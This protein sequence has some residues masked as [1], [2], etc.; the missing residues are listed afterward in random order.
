MSVFNI[1]R[2][3]EEP[4]EDTNNELELLKKLKQRI[5]PTPAPVPI[6]V[7]EDEVVKKIDEDDDVKAPKDEEQAVDEEA[8]SEKVGKKKK[9][10]R[11]LSVEDT[12]FTPLGDVASKE[13]AKVRRVLPKWLAQP[14]VVSVDLGDQQMA[15]DDMKELD[16]GL[17]ETLKSNGVKYFFPVQRQV[18]PQLLNAWKIKFFWPSD[19]CVSAPTGSGKTL[20]FVL[21]IIQTLKTRIVP[22]VRALVILPVQDLAVQVFKVFQ[23]Y[24]NK[25]N[26]RVKLISGQKSFSQEQTE[27]VVKGVDGQF[28]SLADIIIATPGRLVDHIQKT[29][30]FTLNHLRYLVIDEADRVMED[31]QNDWLSHVERSVYSGDRQKMT[32]INCANFMKYQTPLQKLLF[33]ATLS[34]NPEQLQQMSLYEPKLY[35][36]IVQPENIFASKTLESVKDNPDEDNFVGKYTTPSEL[37]E[38]ILEVQ[39]SMKKP[40]LLTNLIKDKEIKKTLVFTKSIDNC[41][42]LATLLKSSNMK[43]G[44]ISSKLKYQRSKTLKAFK[45]DK[46]DVLVSTDALA[47]GIDIG[48]IDLV[49]SYDVPK[50]VKTYIHRIGR[51]AR[52]GRAGKAVTMLETKKVKQFKS[53]LKEAGKST[54]LK[55]ESVEISEKDENVYE[56][57]LKKAKAVIDEE[58]KKSKPP[59]KK[60]ANKKKNKKKMKK[61]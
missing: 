28:F 12:G 54:D 24:A 46:L 52:A 55:E 37:T 43:V 44:E 53:L 14:D 58:N 16:E 57:S 6:K 41:H 42:Y 22:R 51:T 13:K 38:S 21:P 20:A 18:I 35:T 59:T 49:I 33:S 60:D 32:T 10:K 40:L 31:V 39:D 7:H 26:L 30:G 61:K 4:E 3:G 11:K 19:I 2:Y 23:T 45:N 50:F 47:R 17:M 15:V 48:T 1:K 36:S 5:K 27:L 25:T 56:K 34:Q 9:K 29:E 8:K